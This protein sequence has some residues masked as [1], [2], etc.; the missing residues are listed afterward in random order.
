MDKI[1]KDLSLVVYF[2]IMDG[3][4]KTFFYV[5]SFSLCVMANFKFC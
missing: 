2:K 1:I 5:F 4:F 3:T